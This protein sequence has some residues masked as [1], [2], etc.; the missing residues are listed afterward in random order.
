MKRTCVVFLVVLGLGWAAA[1]ADVPLYGVNSHDDGLSIY[2]ADTGTGSFFGRL[3]GGTDQYLTPIAMAIKP[4]Y[5]GIYVWNNSPTAGLLTV[6]PLTG[7]ASP[8]DPLA[9]PQPVI[10]AVAFAADGSLYGAT[11]SSLYAIDPT[12]GV[13]A[14]VGDMLTV[15]DVFG[16]DFDPGGTLYGLT[17]SQQLVTIDTS[18]GAATIVASLDTDVGVPGSIVFS[19]AGALIGSG[20][21]GSQGNILYDIDVSTAAV[22]NIRNTFDFAPQGMGFFPAAAAVDIKP[23]SCP[24][25]VNIKSHGVLPAAVCGTDA[26]DVTTIDPATIL[27]SREGVGGAVSPLRWDTE[28]VCTPLAGEPCEC[29]ELG[30]DGLTD[31][32]LKFSTQE[33]ANALELSGLVGQTVPFTLSGSLLD[34][35]PF[36]GIDCVWVLRPGDGNLDG[37]VDGLDYSKWSLHYLQA[38]A[39]WGEGDYNDDT[40]SDGLDYNIWSLNYGSGYESSP[41]PEP[42]ALVVLTLGAL[43]VLRRRRH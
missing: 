41:V 33:L 6:N 11:G 19:P 43:A 9:P 28:D 2:N 20:F 22:T 17:L 8:V 23:M 38:G 37:V 3:D 35:T 39:S 24:N 21:S 26:F 32:T 30:P 12:T 1:H 13:A 15:S 10:G 7:L 29:H 25:P 36:Q 14:P 34:G 5:A 42:A 27:L 40:I 18:S 4:A 16:M 31:L